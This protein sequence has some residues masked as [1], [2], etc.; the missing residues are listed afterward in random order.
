MNTTKVGFIGTG[1]MGGA[2]AMAV[3]KAGYEVYLSSHS[4]LKAEQIKNNCTNAYIVS[5]REILDI[6]DFVYVG[7]KPQMLDTLVEEINGYDTKNSPIFV[8]ML[9]GIPI[10]TLV[11][12]LGD[13]IIRIMPNTPVKVGEGMTTYSTS[14]NVSKGELDIWCDMMR[15]SGKIDM[16]DERLIDATT[17]IA[18]CSPAYAYYFANA[19]MEAGLEIGLDPNQAKQYVSQMLKGVSAMITDSEDSP[20]KLM[21]DVCSKGGATIR[22]VEV[23]QSEKLQEIVN[24]AVKSSFERTKELSK[25]VKND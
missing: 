13:K 4:P 15:Y 9:A 8:S 7:V 5:N 1:N 25:T 11:S 16:V 21:Q 24:K 22:G 12:K 23:L 3:S 19:L 18:G 14:D 2:I 20:L 10:S 17:V 6:C